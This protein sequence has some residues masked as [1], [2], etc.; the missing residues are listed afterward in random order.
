[1]ASRLVESFSYFDDPEPRMGLPS[2]FGRMPVLAHS[3]SIQRYQLGRE[4][5]PR[6]TAAPRRLA[7]DLSAL[8]LNTRCP[9]WNTTGRCSVLFV[10][11]RG[12]R[13]PGCCERALR[14]SRPPRCLCMA[15]AWC[16]PRSGIC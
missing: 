11:D 4:H 13:E 1:M 6:S 16:G 8:R 9:G 3:T 5:R 15:A 10:L 12:G 14:R 2:W 7:L